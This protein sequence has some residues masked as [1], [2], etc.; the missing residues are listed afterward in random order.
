[1]AMERI[2]QGVAPS[3][4]ARDAFAKFAGIMLPDYLDEREWARIN[5]GD[6]NLGFSGTLGA[7]GGAAVGGLATRGLTGTALG[8]AAGSV[9]GRGV[10][11]YLNT[12]QFDQE[13]PE[14]SEITPELH[15]MARAQA[16]EHGSALGA[17]GGAAAGTWALALGH[18][19]GH[20]GLGGL[21]ALA[22]TYGGHRLGQ[23][24]SLQQ[25]DE[26]FDHSGHTHT[27]DESPK[28]AALRKFAGVKVADDPTAPPAPPPLLD[29]ARLQGVKAP[30]YT[31]SL[32]S[33]MEQENPDYGSLYDEPAFQHRTPAGHRITHL[34][35]R[36]Q[37]ERTK[38]ILG[39]DAY[40]EHLARQAAEAGQNFDMTDLKYRNSIDARH[41]HIM[42]ALRVGAEAA[43]NTATVG[44]GFGAL[45]GTLDVLA[46]AH[47][48]GI[49]DPRAIA[50]ELLRHGGREALHHALRFGLV[51]GATGALVGGAVGMPRPLPPGQP[52]E[53]FVIPGSEHALPVFSH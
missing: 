24:R 40:Y 46:A 10:K 36:S 26:R 37:I 30:V 13:H 14:G 11:S 2:N 8:A 15:D 38:K 28:V 25:F 32:S 49:K 16:R 20:T 1:M 48:Q 34:V 47:K 12:R 21:A 22:L 35:D 6:N 51:G 19:T 53:G 9:L 23:S 17:V 29:V 39:E 3:D 45:A 44:A 52:G 33:T 27:P 31:D 43:K 50:V 42:G 18:A 41:P 4:P 7:L 5:A